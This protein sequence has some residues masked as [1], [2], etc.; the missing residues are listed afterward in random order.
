MPPDPWTAFT[1][2]GIPFTLGALGSA[3]GARQLWHAYRRHTL[4]GVDVERD[5]FP[6]PDP[7]YSLR[8]QALR[9]AGLLAVSA[10]L[11]VHS[12]RWLLSIYGYL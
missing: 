7:G 10:L 4:R 11:L 6:V 9:G 12:G 3:H 5:D 2:F 8:E 1:F